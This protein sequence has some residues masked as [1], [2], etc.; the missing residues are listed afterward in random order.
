MFAPRAVPAVRLYK[1]GCASRIAAPLYHHLVLSDVMSAA[2]R[3]IFTGTRGA[4]QK[5]ELQLA[6]V[7]LYDSGGNSILMPG[8]RASNPG[9]QVLNLHQI[10]VMA[11]DRQL[12]TKWLDGGFRANGHS[13]VL[14]LELPFQQQVAAYNLWTANDVVQRDPVAWTFEMRLADGEWA[15][16]D[17]Q[18]MVPP[19]ERLSPYQDAGFLVSPQRINLPGWVA[20]TR[21]TASVLTPLHVSSPAPSPPPP[22]LVVVEQPQWQQPPQQLPEPSLV[23][24]PSVAP[25]SIAPSSYSYTPAGTLATGASASD[26]HPVGSLAFSS[27]APASSPVGDVASGSGGVA[28]VI[29]GMALVIFL[30]VAIAN[31]AYIWRD[32]LGHAVKNTFGEE[33]YAALLAHVETL[34]A[35][36][37]PLQTVA[38]DA[39][40]GLRELAQGWLGDEEV[41]DGSS[42][43]RVAFSRVASDTASASL[44]PIDGEEA[45]CVEMAAAAEEAEEVH[46]DPDGVG[47]D[48]EGTAPARAKMFAVSFS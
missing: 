7:N 31:V 25:S 19:T 17:E 27:L 23:H 47:S 35:Q 28:S 36:L 43:S 41:V 1:L 42:S 21:P 44:A 20:P 46:A 11:V 3:F 48:D 39:I 15:I 45:A 37:H 29:V 32:S 33:R 13:S 30:G 9:G 4:D 26:T 12:E 24:A 38:A 10:A 22:P 5:A 2:Y 40:G 8:T 16:V 14:Q 6:E 34:R 18:S